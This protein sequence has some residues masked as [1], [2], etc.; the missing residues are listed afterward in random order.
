M[1][2]I[3]LYVLLIIIT[4]I[5][6]DVNVSH[7]YSIHISKTNEYL[8]NGNIIDLVINNPT[9]NTLTD[10]I[11]SI[12]NVKISP[13]YVLNN[14]LGV[15]TIK[16][17]FKVNDENFI[18]QK[19]I[20][21]YSATKPKLYT[22][23]I[24]NEFDHDINSY[25]Q[26]LEFDDDFNL[27]E[28]T[29]QYGFSTLKKVDFKT[30]KVLNKIIL[31]KSYFGEGIT[32]IDDKIF[33]LTWKEKVGFVYNKNDF[34]L[35]KS[36]SYENSLEGWGLCNDGEKLYKSDGTEK[37]WVLDPVNL[38]E[39]YNFSVVTDNKIIK[40]INELEWYEGKIYANTYQF[41]KEVGLIIDPKSGKVEG[42]IDFNGLKTKVKQ[43]SKLDVLN[44][45]AY[46]KQ[47]KT[48]FVTGKN[49]NKLFE[50]KILENQ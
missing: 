49:W 41:N 14:E 19:N 18:I 32:I 33:Q 7:D 11:F 34:N 46:N 44:G 35:I 31:D 42:V 26:G 29:G 5:S 2:V 39:L 38:N 25:T 21:I 45:I 13:N 27:Y 10:L 1:R 50:I 16:A 17:S 12:D 47:R 8:N 40:K 36:F 37:I 22:Y 15:N 4:L 20:I 9:N 23:K 43:H 6:C 3:K 28:G 24:I 48:F 30:G